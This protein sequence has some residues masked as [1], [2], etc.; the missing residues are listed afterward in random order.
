MPGEPRAGNVAA[1][2]LGSNSFHLVIARVVDGQILIVDRVREPVRLL[3]GLDRNRQLTD[4]AE[5]RALACLARFGQRL[6]DL[7]PSQVRAVGTSALRQAK[8]R[9]RFL[10][11]GQSALGHPIEIIAGREEARLIHLG[12]AH[13]LAANGG[14]RLVIDIG[15]GSTECILGEGFE[16]LRTESLQMG[17]VSHSLEHFPKGR[18]DRECFRRAEI[19]ARREIRSLEREFRTIGWES[20]AGSSGTIT[21]IAEILRAAGW[22]R[23]GIGAGGLRKLKRAMIEAGTLENLHLEGL[24]E[25][26][27]PVLAGGLAILRAVFDGLGIERMVPSPGA[28]REGVLF[29][30]L[31]RIR[32]EDIRDRTIRRFMDRYH[33]DEAQAA[34]VERTARLALRQ[35]ADAWDLADPAWRQ[36]LA[37]AAH[38]HEAGMAVAYG[39]HHKHGAYLVANS[40]LPGFSTDEQSFL[41]A[42]IRGHRRR[43]DPTVFE[44]LPPSHAAPAVRL[45]VLLRLAVLLNRARSPR[46]PPGL[47]F[48]TGDG[49]GK[50]RLSF[51]DGWLEHHPLTRADLEEEAAALAPLGLRLVVA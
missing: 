29:D 24:K 33:V 28:L 37:W 47:R 30:L 9:R 16:A 48:E 31:G 10:A 43:I 17:C 7:P 13:S 11:R 27:A 38:V 45:C 18:L 26:R 2:D 23:K 40:D 39:G 21:A 20:C 15:G 35:V 32:H 6:R 25:D 22:S 50:L 19:A 12:V 42:L 36:L 4:E 14:R 51:Q 3:A 49:G 44:G 8:N 41:A 1:V 34:R 46:R 5:E